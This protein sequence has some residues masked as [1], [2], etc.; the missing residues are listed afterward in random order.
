MNLD[1]H[2]NPSPEGSRIDPRARFAGPDLARDHTVSSR[3]GRVVSSNRDTSSSAAPG[4]EAGGSRVAGARGNFA[5]GLAAATKPRPAAARHRVPPRLL[6]RRE[7]VPLAARW[8]WARGASVNARNRRSVS[9]SRRLG[10]GA[11]FSSFLRPEPGPE[12]R[13]SSPC[14]RNRLFLKPLGTSPRHRQL[15][16]DD[17]VHVQSRGGVERRSRRGARR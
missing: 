8:D 14:P 2:A 4:D 9:A 17:G 1:A 7:A 13:P 12:P 6:R 15:R 5:R 3:V 16:R 11:C 10:V